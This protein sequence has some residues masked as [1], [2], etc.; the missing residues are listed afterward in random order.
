II[1]DWNGT[2]Y[3]DVQICIDA[4]NE[5]LE[6][7]G[8]DTV[9]SAERYKKIFC[10]PVKKYYERIGFDFSVHPFEM[11]AEEYISLYSKKEKEA[12]LFP[13]TNTVLNIIS[14]SC[15][16]Q[17]VISACEKKRLAKQINLFGIMKYFSCAIGTDDN[18]AVS[19]VELA[20]KWVKDNHINTDDVVF[21]GDTTH[22]YEVAS[23]VGCDCILVCGGHQSTDILKKTGAQLVD[24]IEGVIELI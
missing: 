4:M 18:L 14:K 12:L 13:N 6:M 7:K 20:K 15:A 11:L 21:I 16:V 19:K 1:W 24:N 8:Y 9:L 17:T 5:L 10:F 3:N 23:A 22:D 2:L